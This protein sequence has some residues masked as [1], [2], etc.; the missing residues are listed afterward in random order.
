M[1]MFLILTKLIL[2]V[3]DF[4]LRLVLSTRHRSLYTTSPVE[5]C[6]EDMCWNNFTSTGV[7]K[8]T[9]A[10]NTLSMANLTQWRSDYMINFSSFKHKYSVENKIK[11]KSTNLFLHFI[12][13]M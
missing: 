7:P 3:T 13:C 2:V 9:L 10:Q 4:K 6:Q 12:C 8:T 11:I 5:V 1:L